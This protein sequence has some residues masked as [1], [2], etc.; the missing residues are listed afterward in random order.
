MQSILP[1]N[2]NLTILFILREPISRAVS[3]F[4]NSQNRFHN[5]VTLDNFLLTEMMI[6]KLCYERTLSLRKKCESS[7]NRMS[8]L[9]KCV[10]QYH[11]LTNSFHYWYQSLTSRVA[12]LDENW[13]WG[14]ADKN[15][16]FPDA[17][18]L[19][20]LY[21][22][23]IRNYICA[24]FHPS[25][26][27]IVTYSQLV[28]SHISILSK[29]QKRYGFSTNITT[30]FPISNSK[31]HGRKPSPYVLRQIEE[32]FELYNKQAIDYILQNGFDV[33]IDYLTMELPTKYP[34]NNTNFVDDPVFDI[35]KYSH[36][37]SVQL[38]LH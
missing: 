14:H 1:N 11:P 24:G 10:S 32:F 12:H 13:Q 22:D 26:I 28:N 38:I 27:M 34:Q 23:Q 33:D 15:S 19:R 21:I 25:Q 4:F 17:V 16:F 29:I 8:N 36:L 3:G 35:F 20:G 5:N 9:A 2:S 7:L 31:S 18:L 30:S 6:L 37:V